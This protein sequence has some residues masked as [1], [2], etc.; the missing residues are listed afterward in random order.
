[1][2]TN[3]SADQLNLLNSLVTIAEELLFNIPL[4]ENVVKKYEKA[5]NKVYNKIGL[6][7]SSS[8]WKLQREAYSKTIYNKKDF[9]FQ[10]NTDN[11]IEAIYKLKIAEIEEKIEGIKWET[12][13][14][15]EKS[16]RLVQDYRDLCSMNL[17]FTENL[18]NIIKSFAG[19]T[20]NDDNFLIN[21]EE[22]SFMLD[23]QNDYENLLENIKNLQNCKYHKFSEMKS[24]NLLIQNNVLIS[25]ETL[26]SRIMACDTKIEELMLEIESNHEIYQKEIENYK[27]K[28]TKTEEKFK[29]NSEELSINMQNTLKDS[30]AEYQAKE[31]LL[32]KNHQNELKSLIHENENIKNELKSLLQENENLKN[33]LKSLLQENENLKQQLTSILQEEKKSQ[34]TYE[35]LLRNLKIEIN[36]V[37]SEKIFLLSELDKSHKN[38]EIFKEKL[39]DHAKSLK[40]Q[41]KIIEEFEKENH[42]LRALNN[43]KDHEYHHECENLENNYLKILQNIEA[44][45]KS[46]FGNLE[47]KIFMLENEINE[48]NN[49]LSKLFEEFEETTQEKNYYN[50]LLTEKIGEVEGLLL[51]LKT[52]NE[53]N[54]LLSKKFESAKDRLKAIQE[55][56]KKYYFELR[57]NPKENAKDYFEELIA[58]LPQLVNDKEWLIRKITNLSMNNP[59]ESDLKP[60]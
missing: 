35:N 30:V 23:Y 9:G 25:L 50:G 1:M 6:P 52:L 51:E 20:E 19:I 15:I 59:K 11:E 56:S 60:V 49:H 28:L 33:E 21:E 42:R 44:A 40:K 32:I 48:K 26:K 29:Q 54:A 41:N 37:S 16:F 34:E 10:V 13:Q 31:K 39:E 43:Q 7:S 27:N 5:R 8:I 4:P 46:S 24:K 53:E 17:L 3:N 57:S 14:S 36:E 45:D 55:T 58:Y 47:E 12:V 22:N 18:Y 2:E 38:I